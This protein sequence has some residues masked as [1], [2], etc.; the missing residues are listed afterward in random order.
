M[1]RAQT[2]A[3]TAEST[4]QAVALAEEA[5]RQARAGKTEE[6]LALFRQALPLAPNNV[7]IL[8]DYA[9]IL[10]WGEHYSDAAKVIRQIVA[11][12]PEQPD[13]AL[14]EY[15]RSYLFGGD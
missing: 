7:P 10:G 12:E 6:A 13:W 5:T 1:D 14:R 4:R 2:P 9:V 3:T 15:A 8:R 11:L